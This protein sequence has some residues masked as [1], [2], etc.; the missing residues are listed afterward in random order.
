MAL[1]WPSGRF[2]RIDASSRDALTKTGTV[3][4]SRRARIFCERGDRNHRKETDRHRSAGK[5]TRG[6]GW[7]HYNPTPV[8]VPRVRDI[9]RKA[10]ADDGDCCPA[11]HEQA[12]GKE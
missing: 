4:K 8:R 10:E 3:M 7:N 11:N 6:N 5:E 2:R 9:L 1:S 12:G